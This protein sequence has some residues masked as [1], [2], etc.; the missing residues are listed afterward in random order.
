MKLLELE[1]QNVR[2]IL[3]LL[4]KPDGNNFAIWGP[5][6]SG[7]SAVVDAVDFL[8]TGRISRLMGEGTGGITLNKHGPHIDHKPSE[9]IVRAVVQLRGV[10]KPVEIKRCM[11]HPGVLEY[12]KSA[13]AQIRPIITLAQRGQYVLTRREI[14][15]YITADAGSRAQKI[16]DLLNISDIEITRKAL[17]KVKNDLDGELQSAK[18]SFDKARAEVSATV[19]EQTFQLDKVLLVVN[20]NRAVLGGQTI[21]TL[22]SAQLKVGLKPPI[23]VSTSPAVNITLLERDL[24]NL[25]DITSTQN[26]T[27]IV[28]NE[29]ELRTQLAS[30]RSAPELL[31]VLPRL[32]LTRLGLDLVDDTGRCPLCDTNWPAG[33]LRQ[34]LE[35]RLS[36]ALIASRYQE[37]ISLLSDTIAS[38]VNATVASLR[39]VIAAVQIMGLDNDFSLLKLWLGHLLNLSNALKDPLVNYP[40]PCYSS[41]QVQQM[42]ATADIVESF[43]RFSAIAKAKYPEETPEQTTWD[44]LTRLEENAK[45]LESAE[46]SFKNAVIS[47]QRASFLLES[48]QRAR[49]KVLGKLYEDVK[50]RFVTLYR[51]LHSNDENDFTAKI[52]PEGAGLNLEV[53]FYGRGTHPP[54]ALHSEG[55]QDSMGLCLYLTLAEQL[56]HGI[57]DLVILDDVVMSVDTEHRRQLCNLLV[58]F[59]PDR[60]FLITTHDG[61]WANQLKTTG[62]VSPRET[63]E[64]RNWSVD[65]GPE[66]YYVADIMW[67][68]IEESLKKARI[69]RAAAQ[70]RRGLEE[71]FGMVCDALKVSVVYKLDGKPDL[72]E[73]LLPALEKYRELIKKAQKVAKSWGQGEDLMKLQKLDKIRSGVYNRTFAEQWAV[74]P[75]VHYDKWV[76]FSEQDFRPVVDAFRDLYYLFICITCGGMLHITTEDGKVANIR[77]KCG[78]VNWNL[79]E[80]DVKN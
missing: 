5:N 28:T 76:N 53:D 49:D 29:E 26:Q 45:S 43:A 3:H 56:N 12:D 30:V 21:S 63:L 6:G 36:T 71:V 42:L 67:D 72:G 57:I 55:H 32:E 41:N 69:P 44:T 70:L 62:V 33:E 19:Q 15:K 50:V 24:Q 78:K 54:H 20:R 64:F 22:Q 59:F 8:L 1:I 80:N 7:K 79:L 16:Q 46:N 10:V 48:F 52:T 74:N 58:K 34:Y 68:E 31:N 13:E 51:Q 27:Q 17:V 35:H 11:A 9:A 40:H 23:V 2:G 47:Q 73:L 75:N 66:V 37:R 60:Q 14:L 18:H 4:L 25:E 65:S 38:S 61:T 77:C 39:K